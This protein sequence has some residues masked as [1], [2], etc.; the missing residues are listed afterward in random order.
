MDGKKMD[1]GDVAC[2]SPNR[3]AVI[4]LGL[5]G[6]VFMRVPLVEALHTRF[7]QAE[8]SMVVDRVGAEVIASHR[9]VHEVLVCHRKARKRLEEGRNVLA[10]AFQLRR[11]CFD[12]VVDAYGGGCSPLLTWLSG[13]QVRVGFDHTR[14]LRAACTHRVARAPHGSTWI[15]GLAR[16]LEPFGIAAA[17]VRRGTTFRCSDGARAF[18]RCWLPD[19]RAY[20]GINLGASKAEKRW[21]ISRFA[22]VAR[23]VY[24]EYGIVPVVFTNPDM[25]HLVEEFA[26][27][28]C[29]QEV[30]VLPKTCLDNIGAV[31]ERCRFVLTGDTGLMHLAFGLRRPVL[32]LFTHTRPEWIAPDDACLESC[33]IEHPTRRDEHGL[34][35]GTADIPVEMVVSAVTKLMAQ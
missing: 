27:Y 26:A 1:T 24:S 23:Y 30:V 11:R 31:M 32:G 34:P 2:S 18:A 22:A 9:A 10:T 5:I 3:I 35:T 7:P 20:F 14:R 4:G 28:H 13:A 17:D 19:G 33:F 21:P 15:A 12:A 6:D 16:L 25:D 29:A 8:I